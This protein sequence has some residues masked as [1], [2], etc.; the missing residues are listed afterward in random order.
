VVPW[1]GVAHPAR[2]HLAK[3]LHVGDA[4]ATVFLNDYAHGRVIL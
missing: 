2:R 3:L 1:G 4:A